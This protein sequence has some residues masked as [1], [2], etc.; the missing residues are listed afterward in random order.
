MA[1]EERHT[2]VE[3]TLR[4]KSL[5]RLFQGFLKVI[6]IILAGLYLLNTVLSYFELD[7]SVISYMAGIGIIPWLFLLLASY[8]LRFCEWHRMFLWYIAA[9]N[10]ICW[11]DYTFGLPVT[12]WGYVMVHFIVAGI[13]LFLIL[14]FRLKCK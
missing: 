4:S 10:I 7:Y 6:P 3:E 2:N 13:F 14:Y 1:V 5:Y 9:H 12:D 11:A 8:V